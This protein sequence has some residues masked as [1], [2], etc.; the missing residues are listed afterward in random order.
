MMSPTSKMMARNATFRFQMVLGSGA[1]SSI[2]EQ[3]RRHSEWPVHFYICKT[4]LKFNINLAIGT[5]M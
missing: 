2:I 3:V 4:I 1:A 5:N